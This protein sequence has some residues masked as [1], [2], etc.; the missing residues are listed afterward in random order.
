MKVLQ[1]NQSDIAGGAGIAGY[2]LHQALLAQG[3][4]SNL[5]VGR[6]LSSD[7]NVELL[8]RKGI[9]DRSLVFAGQAIG[10]NYVLGRSGRRLARHPSVT[11][12]DV[13]NLHNLHTGYINYLFL[14]PLIRSKPTVLTLHDMWAFTGHC[15]Y[16]FDC[17]RWRQ[18]CGQCPDKAAYPAVFIDN[19]RLEHRLK[20][21]VF[22]EGNLS[23]VTPS[24]WLAA[25]AR[26]SLLGKHPVECI[27]NGVDLAV[28]RPLD[29]AQCRA[30]LGLPESVMVLC[31]AAEYL[32]DTRKG[33]ALLI[34]ALRRL[35]KEAKSSLCLLTFGHSMQELQGLGIHTVE[36]GYLGSDRL[37]AVVYSAADAFVL[38]SMADNLPLVL[39]EAMA[40]GTPLVGFDA[41]GI[42][43]LVRDGVTGRLAAKGDVDSL[44]AAISQTM[45]DATTRRAMGAQCVA[46][47]RQEFDIALQVERYTGLYRRLC[48]SGDIA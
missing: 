13:L 47:A 6:K 45:E 44:A 23:V 39:Q 35:S 32:N 10:L 18:G 4:E 9:V 14:R 12:A 5:L 43:E 22:G 20:R 11:Q 46:V 7:P 42:P 41:G 36:M 25:L 8:G 21:H 29:K 15:A 19:T 26:D 34:E 28:F 16:S 48:A 37:K 38:P 40:C 30:I 17:E 24:R 33:G 1:I 2:R 27:P 31:F 3:I